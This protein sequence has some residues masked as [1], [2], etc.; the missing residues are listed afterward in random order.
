VSPDPPDDPELLR[1]YRETVRP[2]YAYVSRHVGGD[3]MLAE[4]LVQDVWMRAIRAWMRDGLPREPLA[5]LLTSAH[6]VVVSHYRRARPRVV[7]PESVD[8]EAPA[9]TP[10]QPDTAAIV[11][12]ALTRVRRA[13]AELLEAFYFDG[14]SVRQIAGERGTSERAIEG[15]LRRARLT[16]KRVIDRARRKSSAAPQD[17]ARRSTEHG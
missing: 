3:R 6:H 16:L 2:L 5:W 10:D 13:H 7:D 14:K 11:N 9:F 17:A 4:D 15:R 8:L 12:W 1:T